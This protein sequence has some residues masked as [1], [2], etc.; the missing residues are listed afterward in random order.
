VEKAQ[1]RGDLGA[2]GRHAV[3]GE[4]RADPVEDL[5][6]ACGQARWGGIR[7]TGQVREGTAG[8]GSHGGTV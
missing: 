7:G 1:P 3:R 6:L 5:L 8:A 4:V 2:R